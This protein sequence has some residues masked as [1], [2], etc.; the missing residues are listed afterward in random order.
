MII[1]LIRNKFKQLFVIM[2]L[3]SIT[4]QLSAQKK[5]YL[6]Q[7]IKANKVERSTILDFKN[8]L[9]KVVNKEVLIITD[10]VK[11]PTDGIVFLLGTIDSNKEVAKFS[12]LKKIKL[13]TSYPGSRGG[14]WAKLNQKNRNKIIVIAGSDVEGL[15]YS[16][17][18]Y[19]HQVL[20]VDPFE[21]WTGKKPKKNDDLDFF[22]FKNK[23]IKPPLV[24]IMCY[25]ENDVDELANY[26]GKKLEYDWE[27]YTEMINS[28]VRIRYNSIQFFDMLGRPEFFV[29]PE[30]K[31]LS[32]DYQV[33]VAYFDKM[34]DYAHLKG[35]KVQIDLSLGYQMRSLSIEESY[36]W[37][38]YKDKWIEAWKYYFEKTPIGK[39]DIFSLRPRHQVW[40]WEY[41]SN[42]GEDKTAVFNEVYV[43]LGK[44]I[45][46]YKPEAT[47]IAFCYHDGMEM[48]NEDFNP[49]KDWTVVW[50]DDGFG[51]FDH[52]PK[53]TKGYDFGTYMHAGFWKNHTV[54]NPY[55]M[56][57]DIIM[58]KM[59]NDYGADKYCQV[60][61]QNFRPFLFNLEAYSEVCN[62]PAEFNGENFY[63]SWTK[64]YFSEKAAKYAVESMKVLHKAQVGRNGYVQHLWEISE[65]T[66]YLSNSPLERPGKEP[67]PYRYD[68]V[69]N[70]I[71]N[72]KRELDMFQQ[73]V[74]TAENGAKVNKKNKEFYNSYILL[75]VTLYAD[76]IK[77]ERTL[78]Q[79]A[80]LKK[81]FEDTCNRDLI[82][83][84]L[85][86]L[87][88]AE[89]QLGVVYKNSL[90][91]DGNPKWENWYNPEIRRPNNGFPKMEDI[92]KIRKVLKEIE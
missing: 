47:K 92:L 19:S 13:S 51:D 62:N 4:T 82:I 11:T 87:D 84:A 53:S 83:K 42:C 80:L 74:T 3:F 8:D 55:P 91:G 72:L 78:H 60:N 34:I 41:I 23:T 48:F 24:P 28:L 26:R 32:P 67:V 77:F 27:S 1:K 14:I 30:Y 49:P 79:I 61:G 15:Q 73:A 29:R 2:V 31:A 45:N 81:G 6:V 33:D 37:T 64:R 85:L 88:K 71:D 66:S 36:C 54:H 22:N 38:T 63:K 65:A 40:D 86:L 12:K 56:K 89:T 17:Y 90:E 76:L 57:V 43:E 18:D 58:K 21:Y 16:I 69:Y 75:P 5:V 10:T 39:A 9:L 50:C 35:M 46:H 70:D 20:G 7:G 68:R 59:F 52:L 44:L 25:F